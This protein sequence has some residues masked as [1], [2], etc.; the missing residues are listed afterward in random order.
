MPH[1]ARFAQRSVQQRA[2]HRPLQL[3]I[4]VPERPRFDRRHR[5]LF[6]ASTG[7]DD[8]RH[9]VQLISQ[10][11][12]QVQ[13]VHPG[14]L[15]VR[16]QRIR[17]IARVFRQRFFR[18]GNAQHVATP[19]LQ[20]LFVA[21]ARVVFVFDNQ[22]AV[23]ALPGFHRAHC[24]LCVVAHAAQPHPRVYSLI[25]IVRLDTSTLTRP[26]PLAKFLALCWLSPRT[27]SGGLQPGVVVPPR[28]RHPGG[29]FRREPV[30]AGFS[31]P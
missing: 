16:D 5:A 15:D 13:P 4:Y 14:Q 10:L 1:V 9:I 2:Q 24:C 27:R 28:V 25:V 12:Q 19:P 8:R 18:A 30:A 11:L 23:F 17:L 21:F 20:E 29:V 31:S 7:D 3:P 6:A 26:S 22:H